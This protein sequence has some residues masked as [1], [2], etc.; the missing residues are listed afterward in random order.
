MVKKLPLITNDDKIIFVFG[1]Y[2]SLCPL[3]T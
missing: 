3:L 2:C 1:E